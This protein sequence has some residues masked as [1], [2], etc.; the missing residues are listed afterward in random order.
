[1]DAHLS[2][3]SKGVITI[4]VRFANDG[5]V[6][7]SVEQVKPGTKLGNATYDDIDRLGVGPVNVERILTLTRA[8]RA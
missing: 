6:G 2:K 3:D 8:R 7:D 5:A 4:R 1:V